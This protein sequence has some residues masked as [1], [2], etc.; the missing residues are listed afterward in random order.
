MNFHIFLILSSLMLVNARWSF[1]TLENR[2]RV[3]FED[4]LN[5]YE[6]GKSF[7][8]AKLNKN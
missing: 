5:S 3:G 6:V 4:E 2:N 1:S 7:H 8:Y